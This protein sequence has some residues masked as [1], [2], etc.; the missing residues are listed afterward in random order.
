MF[1]FSKSYDLCEESVCCLV[2]R[3]HLPAVDG[4]L[5]LLWL[6]EFTLILLIYIDLRIFPRLLLGLIFTAIEGFEGL[7]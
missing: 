3:L 2:L 5:T 7:H 1:F 6:L 4:F